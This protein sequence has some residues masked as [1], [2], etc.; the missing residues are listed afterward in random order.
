MLDFLLMTCP[1]CGGY[2][3]VANCGA[4][5]DTCQG[6]GEVPACPECGGDGEFHD[7]DDDSGQPAVETCDNCDGSGIARPADD[8]D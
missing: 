8:R 4:P 3:S 5:C 7:E 2:H 1:N 6:R